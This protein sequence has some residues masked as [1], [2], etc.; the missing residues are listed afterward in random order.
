MLIDMKYSAKPPEEPPTPIQEAHQQ[1]IKPSLTSLLTEVG[2][3][4]QDTTEDIISDLDGIC[5]LVKASSVRTDILE[6]KITSR[7]DKTQEILI[8]RQDKF[9]EQITLRLD[10]MQESWISRLDI[11]QNQFLPCREGPCAVKRKQSGYEDGLNDK[12]SASGDEQTV[13]SK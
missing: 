6:Q 5:S 10:E 1:D 12:K 9:Q 3:Y 2:R 13:D 4:V 7:L 11:L 8:S